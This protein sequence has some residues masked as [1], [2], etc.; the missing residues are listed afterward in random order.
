MK[1]GQT[2]VIA[3]TLKTINLTKIKTH[4]LY[5]KRKITYTNPK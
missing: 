1:L 4:N 3:H 5:T 2:K